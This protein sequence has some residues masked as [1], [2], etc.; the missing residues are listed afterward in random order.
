MTAFL[1]LI[2]FLFS[3]IGELASWRFWLSVIAGALL[4]TFLAG[5]IDLEWLQMATAV[6]VMLASAFLG[7]RWESS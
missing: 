2:D 6:A 5:L 3:F 4:T 7:L 1:E